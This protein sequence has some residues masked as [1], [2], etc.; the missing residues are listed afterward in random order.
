MVIGLK[1]NL[2]GGEFK[3]GRGKVKLG[4][5]FDMVLVLLLFPSLS[6]YFFVS[7]FLSISFHSFSFSVRL[8]FFLS[9]FHSLSFFF[10][11]PVF[12]SFFSLSSD[13]FGINSE[14]FRKPLDFK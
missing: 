4:G 3:T 10:F 1:S 12:L 5:V 9:F 14:P 7:F 6:I 2:R 11:Q 13:V 8:S